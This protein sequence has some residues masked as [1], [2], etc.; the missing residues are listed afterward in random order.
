MMSIFPNCVKNV[1]VHALSDCV[2]FSRRLRQKILDILSCDLTTSK[3]QSYWAAAESV[4]ERGPWAKPL[5]SE[6]GFGLA[7]A[8][9]VG[10]KAL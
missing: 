5:A 10:L 3:D 8:G 7:N 9:L 4:R 6:D 1:R 2:K